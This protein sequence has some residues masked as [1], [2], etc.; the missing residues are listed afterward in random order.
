MTL[1]LPLR[2]LAVPC[3]NQACSS[4]RDL[5]TR[6]RELT[7]HE[8]DGDELDVAIAIE[9]QL[10]KHHLLF[11]REGHPGEAGW[12]RRCVNTGRAWPRLVPGPARPRVGV[13]LPVCCPTAS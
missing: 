1:P 4:H 10:L 2:L 7:Q 8:G 9:S 12:G 5:D 13:W 3:L 11:L 6:Q